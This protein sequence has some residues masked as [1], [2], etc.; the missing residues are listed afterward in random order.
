MSQAAKVQ[1]ND[2]GE[3]IRIPVNMG[4]EAS[5]VD[6]FQQLATRTTRTQPLSRQSHSSLMQTCRGS[7]VWAPLT[8]TFT[9]WTSKHMG[10]ILQT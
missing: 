8:M 9:M 7:A 10:L 5:T 2:G 4:H 6:I 3:R 1:I